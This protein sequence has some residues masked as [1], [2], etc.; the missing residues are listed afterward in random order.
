MD[1]IISEILY[2]FQPRISTVK[3]SDTFSG[4]KWEGHEAEHLTPSCDE[5][6]ECVGGYL[7]SHTRLHGVV[8]SS[9]TRSTL[10]LP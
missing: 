1:D 3:D 4:L 10:P 6:K 2:L 7:Y 8:L 9:S 5:V